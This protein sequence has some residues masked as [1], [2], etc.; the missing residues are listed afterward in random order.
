M[1]SPLTGAHNPGVYGLIRAYGRAMVGSWYRV[2]A[3]GER[4][5]EQGALILYA[6]HNG[7][8]VDGGLMWFLTGRQL[9]FIAKYTLLRM[10]VLGVLIRAAGTIPVYRKKDNVDTSL[11]QSS[12]AAIDAAL[13]GGEAIVLYP[14]GEGGTEPYVRPFK[15]G[16][17]RMALS[18][19]GSGAQDLSLVPV[20]ITYEE[21]DRY[22]SV[23]HATIGAS[24]RLDDLAQDDA[25][26]S[27]VAV[28][29][30]RIREALRAQLPEHEDPEQV[31][32]TQ[33]A[34]DL[35]P[36]R[37]RP[38]PARMRAVVAGIARL[39]AAAPG[40]AARLQEQ[41]A[42]C[43]AELRGLGLGVRDVA[44]RPSALQTSGAA[45]MA[46]ASGLLRAA[47]HVVWAP[48]YLPARAVA[49]RVAPRDKVVTFTLI[50]SSFAGLVWAIGAAT[51]AWRSGGGLPAAASAVAILL[52]AWWVAAHAREAWD[53]AAAT[54]RAASS[55]KRRV[56]PLRQR[57]EPL[58]RE[59]TRRSDAAARL[60]RT[61]GTA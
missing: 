30:T 52:A 4:V 3:H 31:A 20:A 37:G 53:R 23:L 50:G 25:P 36:E 11:N 7:G 40:R 21:R 43:A 60:A 1:G 34:A 29:T 2:E 44:S 55:W 47:A 12:F 57:L 26:P 45:V 16:T 32:A 28:A 39:R 51:W 59:L 48:A 56:E 38:L 6:N 19:I 35:V 49:S 8:L 61:G 14:E 42:A 5:P 13:V 54:L 33:L 58:R 9:R 18:A 41:L 27:A 22:R 15:T 46:L 24:V 10:P 17:A